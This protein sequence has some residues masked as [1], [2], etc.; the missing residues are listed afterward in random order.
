VPAIAAFVEAAVDIP[1]EDVTPATF[2]SAFRSGIFTVFAIFADQGKIQA[3]LPELR[4]AVFF[5]DGLVLVKPVPAESPILREVTG[6]HF[7]GTCAPGTG[8]ATTLNPEGATVLAT[9]EA[10]PSCAGAPALTSHPYGRG[11]ARV[12]AAFP[13]EDAFAEAVLATSRE[14]ADFAGGLSAGVTFTVGNPG[15]SAGYRL[16]AT[17]PSG[18]T[19]FVGTLDTGE[20]AFHA[21][22]FEVPEAGGTLMVDGEA[23]ILFGAAYHPVAT[24]TLDLLVAPGGD[25]LWEVAELEVAASAAATGHLTKARATLDL[26]K[27]TSRLMKAIH[28]WLEEAPGD[29]TAGRLALDRL[30]R[31]T[32]RHSVGP[33]AP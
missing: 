24:L 19:S 6:V 32:E 1:H 21:L 26:D 4:E 29:T 31:V 8:G 2:A 20:S 27:R 30:L 18:S 3:L 16:V 25:A 22:V 5:G 13:E 7:L 10:P 9:L 17:V 12:F 33:G 11:E 23:A 28:G 15:P 14:V